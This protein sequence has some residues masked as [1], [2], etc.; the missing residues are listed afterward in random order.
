MN[1]IDFDNLI[2]GMGAILFFG[3]LVLRMVG[4]WLGW[5]RF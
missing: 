5:W 1:G 4:A 3:G 2:I